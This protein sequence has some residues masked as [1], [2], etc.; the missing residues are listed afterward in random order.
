MNNLSD[1]FSGVA[2]AGYVEPS[3]KSIFRGEFRLR[4][5]LVN[6][7]SR[8]FRQGECNPT[9][10]ASQVHPSAINV[11]VSDYERDLYP[12]NFLRTFSWFLKDSDRKSCVLS[13]SARM[14]TFE[15]GHGWRT[16][17]CLNLAAVVYLLI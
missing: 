13:A 2:L 6:G 12:Q 15:I 10:C 16:V 11:Q 5:V 14:L 7:Q 3:Q 17:D 1:Y 8:F 4:Y 9:F